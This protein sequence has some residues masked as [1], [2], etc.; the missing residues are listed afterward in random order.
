MNFA[1]LDT[2]QEFSVG[3]SLRKH[4]RKSINVI[5]KGLVLK[6]VHC[7]IVSIAGMT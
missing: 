3:G 6:F 4:A 2:A 5:G 1:Y 7:W